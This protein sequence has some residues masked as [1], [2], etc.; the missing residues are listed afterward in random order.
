MTDRE[1]EEGP[2]ERPG[3]HPA[4]GGEDPSGGEPEEPRGRSEEPEEPGRPPGGF[5]PG[6]HPTGAPP[7]PVTGEPSEGPSGRAQAGFEHAGYAPGYGETDMA[8]AGVGSYPGG[9][10]PPPPP[11]G[12]PWGAPPPGGYGPPPP[13]PTPWGKIIGIGCG[14]LLLLLL[15]LGGCTALLLVAAGGGGTSP[16]VSE[17]VGP[18]DTPTAEDVTEEITARMTD[19]EPS[20]LYSD[21]EYTSVEVTITNDGEEEI[22]INPLYFSI[23]D[24]EGV[25][26]ETGE[27]IA[28]DDNALDVQKLDPGETVSG[29][30]T[31]RGAVDVDRIV[32]DP[33]YHGP[34]EVPVA[35]E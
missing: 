11:Q 16:D 25:E 10:P 34:V 27:A 1:P 26:H 7:E 14:V 24:T 4:E 8:G 3:P 9:P 18:G 29:T 21:G 32:F 33:F 12:P 31:V 17:T 23:V 19:F 30:I 15:L 20:P 5:P 35:R 13:K 6:E 2:E 28:L 22:D